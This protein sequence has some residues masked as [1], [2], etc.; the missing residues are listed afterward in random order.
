MALLQCL[1][2]RIKQIDEDNSGVAMIF[3]I[4]VGVVVMVFCL[5]LLLVTYTLYAQ[6]SRQT[7]QMQCKMFAQSFAD[8]LETEITD[9]N[10]DLN[11]YLA[12]AIDSGMWIS[13]EEAAMATDM[14]GKL[15]SL[16]LD[17]SQGQLENYKIVVTLSYSS[18]ESDD[19][20]EPGTSEDDDQD[21]TL[22]AGG[23]ADP[24]GTPGGTPTGNGNYSITAII[25]C[26]RGNLNE[27]DVQTYSI[28][29]EYPSVTLSK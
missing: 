17:M 19:D 14:S 2:K 25:D 12:N 3:A 7:T 16:T 9:E 6:T 27:T 4:I 23:G 26:T 15:S 21:E 1:K 8:I 22:N 28:K 11:Q 13:E 20:S 5:S 10:S 24:G 29:S 18:N